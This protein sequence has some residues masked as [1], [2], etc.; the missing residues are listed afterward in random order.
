MLLKKYTQLGLK[1]Y[2]LGGSF[3][4]RL[5]RSGKRT[6]TIIFERREIKEFFDRRG[7]LQNS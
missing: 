4:K 6:G 5:G 2:I 7:N 3:V 1:K